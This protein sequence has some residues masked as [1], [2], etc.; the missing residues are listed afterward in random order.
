MP[1][2]DSE[3]EELLPAGAGAV[4]GDFVELGLFAGGAFGGFADGFLFEE[5]FELRFFL[6]GLVEARLTVI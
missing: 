4:D 6:V 1:E 5:V 2:N 3:R